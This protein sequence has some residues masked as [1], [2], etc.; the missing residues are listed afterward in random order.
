MLPLITIHPSSRAFQAMVVLTHD[1]WQC[2][3]IRKFLE[4]DDKCLED[5]QV[6]RKGVKLPRVL[7][8]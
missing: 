7:S 4:L 5:A 3:H 8:L 1:D 2:P 6:P